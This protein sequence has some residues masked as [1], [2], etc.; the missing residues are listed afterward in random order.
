M[1]DF[2]K[3]KKPT[4][5]P[6]AAPPKADPTLRFVPPI[7]P[8]MLTLQLLDKR[9]KEFQL[10]L[11]KCEEWRDMPVD[12]SAT[13]VQRLLGRIQE[14]TKDLNGHGMNDDWHYTVAH[15]EAALRDQLG[16]LE[17]ERA[18]ISSLYEEKNGKPYDRLDTTDEW[19]IWKDEDEDEDEE[20]WGN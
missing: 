14:A 16:M 11:E 7:V 13:N 6:K 3:Q 12:K 1:R 4:K 19:D 9:I 8:Y 20:V 17:E 18:H 2:D 5:A 10:H 15:I